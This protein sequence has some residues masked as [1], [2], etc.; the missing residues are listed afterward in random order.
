VED[1]HYPNSLL[2]QTEDRPLLTLRTFSKIYGLAGL[3][4]GYGI[5][6]KE[7]VGLM[8]RVRQPFNVNSV[9]QWAAAAALSDREH[10]RRSIELN[11]KGL[12]L[13]RNGLQSMGINTVPSWAN[14]ILVHV[15]D[16]VQITQE[17]MSLGVIVRPMGGYGYPEHIRVTVGAEE[18]NRR[19]LAA[20]GEVFEKNHR[21]SVTK[22]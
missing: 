9:A 22:S 21:R 8:E 5:G 1:P 13:L 14:F 19:F 17:L 10:V 11:R 3:R 18:E 15:G 2:D 20:L 4:I 16:G 12:S 6:P 7:I